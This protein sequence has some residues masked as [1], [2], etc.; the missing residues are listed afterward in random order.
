MGDD[1]ADEAC[2]LVDGL[3]EGGGEAPGLRCSITVAGIGVEW[4]EGGSMGVEGERLG[5]EAAVGERGGDG[6]GDA[7]R[8]VSGD[9]S[10]DAAI[11]DRSSCDLTFA[12]ANS[13]LASTRLL[14]LSRSMLS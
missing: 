12:A 11:V 8:D 1:P 10:G 14:M 9:S 5:A 2:R 13:C 6:A 4:A 3:L 7:L